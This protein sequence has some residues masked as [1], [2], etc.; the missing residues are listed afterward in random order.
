M[1]VAEVCEIVVA[2][3]VGL[4]L[5]AGFVHLTWKIGDLLRKVNIVVNEVTPNGGNSMKD[6]LA[7]NTR[8]TRRIRTRQET[9]YLQQKIQHEENTAK[10][11]KLE[12]GQLEILKEQERVRKE[13]QDFQARWAVPIERKEA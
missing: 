10:I 3:P 5:V 7:K 12:G 8:I 1:T 13:I 9:Q 11:S 6:Q 4:G 2:V